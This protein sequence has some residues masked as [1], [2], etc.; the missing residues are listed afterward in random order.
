MADEKKFLDQ[1][2]VQYLWSQLS[3]EDYPN[4]ETLIAVLNAIDQ[5]KADKDE[6][7]SGSWN[8]LEDKPFEMNTVITG[9]TVWYEGSGNN[10][11]NDEHLTRL[12]GKDVIV[13]L[14]GVEYETRGVFSDDGTSIVKFDEYKI[15]QHAA[16]DDFAHF[17]PIIDGETYD[18]KI[19]V[20]EKETSIPDEVIS[21]NIARTTYVDEQLS[22]KSDSNH[23]H[24]DL[25]YTET[26]VNNLLNGK[27]NTSELD[28]YY[29][30]PE[31][32]QFHDEIIDY[33]DDEVAALVNSAPETLDTLGELA[34]AFQ[35]NKEVVDVLN[36][37]IA[38]KYSSS[39]PPP[40]PVT[41]VQGKTGAV[42][43]TTET[44]TFTLSNGST[45]TKK[46]LLG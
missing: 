2:G 4:N 32:E 44:W 15:Y 22:T 26:E 42:N 36:E 45:V 24:N 3:M 1:A 18:L 30:K 10:L 6:L 27:V 37:A 25:Y 31:V 20:I 11:R 5:T 29:T 40:Y 14:N 17:V 19:E 41:S 8:D 35:E 7:F 34:E 16:S 33:V 46:V 39:N 43:F 28:N 23:E 13:T 21:D 9:R 38:T 12:D